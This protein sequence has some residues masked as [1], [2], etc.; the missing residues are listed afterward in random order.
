M[1]ASL[2]KNTKEKSLVN[3]SHIQNVGAIYF[4]NQ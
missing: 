2:E 1:E 3:G 4:I